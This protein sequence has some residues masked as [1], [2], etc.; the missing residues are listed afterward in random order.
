MAAL[1]EWLCHT[2]VRIAD[3]VGL[4]DTLYPSVCDD[5]CWST[6]T[7]AVGNKLGD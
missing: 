6:I 7:I 3:T 2:F 4:D 1:L 5:T